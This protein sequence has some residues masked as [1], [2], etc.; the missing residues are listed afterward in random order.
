MLILVGHDEMSFSLQ[1]S[2]NKDIVLIVQRVRDFSMISVL[3]ILLFFTVFCFDSFTILV[4]TAN[5]QPTIACSG[6]AME[7]VEQGVG[8]VWG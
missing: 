2:I 7:T 3:C 5:V 6:L 8:C 1:I 4:L